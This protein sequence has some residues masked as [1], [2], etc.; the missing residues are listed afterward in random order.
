MS[1]DKNFNLETHL[2][3]V[4]FFSPKIGYGF[5]Q[6][7][8]DG[9]KQPDMFAHFSD[10]IMP[11][12]KTLFKSQRVSFQIGQNKNGQPKAINIQVLKH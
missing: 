5:L 7:E 11:G 8:K 6:W 3:E 10:L 4:L 9:V 12:F 2:G 1:E